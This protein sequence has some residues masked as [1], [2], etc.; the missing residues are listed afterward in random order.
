M[1]GDG[2]GLLETEVEAVRVLAEA[3]TLYRH[4]CGLCQVLEHYQ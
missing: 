2:A 3:E 4:R 1:E